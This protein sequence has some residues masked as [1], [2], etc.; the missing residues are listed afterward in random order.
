LCDKKE[1]ERLMQF[2][3]FEIL[4]YPTMDDLEIW[5]EDLDGN[6]EYVSGDFVK[7]VPIIKL[8]SN[9]KRGRGEIDSAPQSNEETGGASPSRPLH[10]SEGA[11]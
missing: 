9:P 1:K 7:S 4:P 11:N 8:K 3:N 5:L 2:A 6:K 10:L